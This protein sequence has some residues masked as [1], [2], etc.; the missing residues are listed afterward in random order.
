ME[1]RE[2]RGEGDQIKF[3]DLRLERLRLEAKNYIKIDSGAAG[4][5]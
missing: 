3:V 4:T 5:S 1:E 2:Q